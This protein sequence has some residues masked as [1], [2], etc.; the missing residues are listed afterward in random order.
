MFSYFFRILHFAYLGVIIMFNLDRLEGMAKEQ[1]VTK[2]HLCSLVGR[3]KYYLNDIKNKGL[4]VPESYIEAWSEAL[5]TTPEYLKGETDVKEKTPAETGERTISD[6]DIMFA[7]WGD[8]TD[9]D[10]DDLDDVKR[11]AAFVRE[12]KKKK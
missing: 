2:T 1:G 10:E 4:S 7:L 6:D 9:V 12:R 11:Y 5:H 3:P 8:T